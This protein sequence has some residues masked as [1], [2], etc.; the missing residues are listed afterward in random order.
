MNLKYLTILIAMLVL[1]PNQASAYYD[2]ALE[3][4]S[5]IRQICPCDII[6]SDDIVVELV[7]YG[8]KSDTY[9]L[10]MEVPG[11][12]SGFIVPEVILASGEWTVLDPMWITP[13]C[14]T[15]P[16]KYVVKFTAESAQS[17]KVFEEELELDVMRCHDVSISGDNYL[18]TC[19]ENEVTSSLE[20]TNLGKTK[21][22]FR[23][24]A[25]PE[26]VTVSPDSV[27]ISAWDSR[28]ISIIADPPAGL[29]GTQEITL[30]AE[31]TLSYAS[32]EKKMKLDIDHC[33]L[34]SASIVPPEDTVCMGKSIEYQ[35]LIDNKGVKSDTYRIVTPAWVKADESTLSLGS[36]R[37][38]SVRL[39]ATPPST[40]KRDMNVYVSSVDHPTS[41]INVEGVLT[42]VDCRSAAV[43][44]SAA[45][46]NVCRGE[47]TDFVLK[48]ENTGSVM[49]AYNIETTMGKLSREK[50]VLGPGEAQ[51]VILDI[52]SAETGIE[53]TYPVTVY[54]FSGEDAT[55]KDSA[56]LVVHKCR[57]ATISVNPV[58][59]NVC[60]GDIVAYEVTVKNTG[61]FDDDYDLTYP[62]GE[63][64][65]SLQP[66]DSILMKLDVPVDFSWGRGNRLPFV[67]KS[68][69][70]VRVEKRVT[71]NVTSDDTCYAVDLI[72]ISGDGTKNKQMNSVIGEGQAVEL[73]VANMGL[74]S[75]SYTLTMSGPDWAYLSEQNVHLSPLQEET[76]YLYL[77]PPED[78]EKM[79]YG[80]TILADSGRALSGVTISTTVLEYLS[81]EDEEVQ[82]AEAPSELELL[83]GNL[84]GMFTAAEP[85]AVELTVISA[86]V[87]F[88]ALLIVLR[89]VVF[90]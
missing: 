36:D 15:E 23:L 33:Y 78:T 30:R 8:T 87:F 21:E 5:E 89:F 19:V 86:L 80:M 53:G 26:W 68:S 58:E 39:T 43:S 56:T 52:T 46:R 10:S 79:D 51:N 38:G 45:E 85:V 83:T 74:R 3:I 1:I 16:G 35:L 17:G 31:S 70:G 42:A 13:P 20:V 90:R 48:V 40:G 28:A 27:T 67:V 29:T 54:V 63:K 49:T 9:F 77:S 22:T 34:F 60:E 55:D 24:S 12:W 18:N 32:T 37:R 72:I 64:G 75:D 44:F 88:T 25:S 47:S 73:R 61:E 76:V 71:L 57:D 7:N 4:T 69:K 84:A 81:A 50:V 65:F 41:I 14:G 62:S 11:E 66:G 59:R 2:A 82:S 6:S